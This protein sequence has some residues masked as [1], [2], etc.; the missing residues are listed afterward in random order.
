MSEEA[1][2]N[3]PFRFLTP[4]ASAIEKRLDPQIILGAIALIVLVHVVETTKFVGAWTDYKSA[5]RALATGTDADPALGSPLLVSSKRIPAD[6]NRLA[7][8]STTPYLSVLVAPGLA[9]ARLVVDP[10]T[11]YFWLSCATAIK[12]EAS[13]T[14]I[15]V[16]AR[17]LIKI[18]SCLHRS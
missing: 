15:P 7:W 13:S 12:S 10:D 2:R 9:P 11:G 18:Y 8:N 6:L 14:A 1:R 5:V 4:L 3:S 16:Q 17:Q